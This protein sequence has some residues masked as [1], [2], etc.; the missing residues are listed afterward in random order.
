ML[1]F[2]I[3]FLLVFTDMCSISYGY[4]ISNNRI[5]DDSGRERIFHGTNVVFKQKPWHPSIY[6]F[7]YNLSFNNDDIEIIYN[8]GLNFV[9]LGVMWPGVEPQK[10]VFNL[11]YLNVMKDIVHKLD[12][13]NISVLIEF[14][15][16]ALSEYFCGEGIP[17]WAVEN[18]KFPLP[19]AFPYNKSGK[20]SREKCLSK[21][22]WNYQLSYEAGSYY[23][24]LYTNTDLRNSFLGYW[25]IIAHT[26]NNSD[27]VIGYEIINEPWAGNIY[28]DLSLLL[29]KI[30]DK[31]NLQPFYDHIFYNLSL[32]GYLNN[33]L[34]FF[35][36]TTWDDWGTGFDH[37]PGNNTEKCVLSFHCY[38]PPDISVS[39]VFRAR[40]NDQKKLNIPLF[41]TE[42]GSNHIF[43]V[44]QNT[45]ELFMSWSVWSYKRFSNITGDGSMFF[46]KNG[47]IA[48]TRNFLNRTYPRSICGR[49]I[50]FNFNVS[51]NSFLLIYDN[52]PNCRGETEIFINKNMKIS[53]TPQIEHFIVDK[54]VY[55][56]PHNKT[57]TIYVSGTSMS[58]SK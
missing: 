52:N 14:H 31:K 9:R 43:D 50:Y 44:F 22:W 47:T 29:P 4:Y 58:L 27:N 57:E 12:K 25:N 35:E 10:S 24:E 51:L 38:F 40:L 15:Q 46:N 49:G 3:L 17:D 8:L 7:N 28:K 53:I 26:F 32:S 54:I 1:K 30:A 34:F 11:T 55:I 33:K 13:K 21:D 19:I 6:D 18:S 20:P 48:N 5:Y 42:F 36:P 39:Q 16:D 56:Q 45:D 41:L 23:Q 2:F 37:P